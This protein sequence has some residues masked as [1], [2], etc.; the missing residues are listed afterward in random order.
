VSALA[1]QGL[2]VVLLNNATPNRPDVAGHQAALARC[3]GRL[4]TVEDHQAIAGAG[5]MLVTA[6]KCAGVDFQVKLLAVPGHF[7]QSAYNAVELYDKYGIG[8]KA[9]IEAAVALCR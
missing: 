7:G 8:P 5:S 2:G 9:M 3:G 4:V 1:A 6:L